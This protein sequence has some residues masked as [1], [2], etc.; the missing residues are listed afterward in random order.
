MRPTFLRRLPGS[1][2]AVLLAVAPL[3]ADAQQPMVGGI[4]RDART[5]EPLECLHVALLDSAARAI[6]H[7]VT[8]AA[9][10]FMLEAPR[11]GV[12]RVQFEIFGW[13][14]MAGPVDTLADGDFKQRIY[15]VAFTTMP[16]PAG[17]LDSISIKKVQSRAFP[18]RQEEMKARLKIFDSLR[19]YLRGQ[20]EGSAWQ[21]RRTDSTRMRLRIPQSAFF[22]GVNGDVIA[23]FIVDSSGSVRRGSWRLIKATHRDFE[24]AVKLPVLDARFLPAR[25]QGQPVCELTQYF[26]RFELDGGKPPFVYGSIWIVNY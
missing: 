9:G 7:T 2:V 20:Q 23:R 22:E 19:T 26:V 24:T 10:R 18:D 11:A 8:D 25:H 6:A 12:Y 5:R 14:P 4:A 21:S 17:A 1:C 15:P 13:D 3:Q 16:L